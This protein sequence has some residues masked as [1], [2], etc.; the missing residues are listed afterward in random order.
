MY[1][2]GMRGE[3]VVKRKGGEGRGMVRQRQVIVQVLCRCPQCLGE[4]RFVIDWNHPRIYSKCQVCGEVVPTGA[5]KIIIT[6]NDQDHP[7][8]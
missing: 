6:S 3:G 7:I 2:C 1:E 5:Y 8:F 4:N